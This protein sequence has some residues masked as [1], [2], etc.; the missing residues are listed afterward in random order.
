MYKNYN[1]SAQPL[2]CIAHETLV[3]VLVFLNSLIPI[4]VLKSLNFLIIERERKT[5]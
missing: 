1:A 4:S 2:Y 5:F 3:A